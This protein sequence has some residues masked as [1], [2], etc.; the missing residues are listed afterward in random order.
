MYK[1]YEYTVLFR[2]VKTES[3]QI[4]NEKLNRSL[5]RYYENHIQ[6]KIQEDKM[7]SKEAAARSKH[8][9]VISVR[10]QVLKALLQVPQCRFVLYGIISK[11][12]NLQSD[13]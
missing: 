12:S 1:L 9:T 8:Y 13:V 4:E 5:E 11:Y 3:I 10:S 6:G 7:R 2:L